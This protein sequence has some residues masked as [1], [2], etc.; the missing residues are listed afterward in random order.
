LL[1][2]R[3]RE[4][5]WLFV[6][7]SLRDIIPEDHILRRVDRVLNLGWLRDEVRELYNENEGR[8]GI[9]P[10]AAVRLML[11]GF[12]HGIV[13]DRKLLREAQV[14]IA[15]RWFAGY[16][17]HEELPDH[18]SLTRIRQRWGAERFKKIFE[19]TVGDCVAHGLVSG[20][21]VHID[22]TL[23]RANASMDSL[24]RIHA[25]A[26]LAANSQDTPDPNRGPQPSGSPDGSVPGS[27]ARKADTVRS[28]TDPDVT[29]AKG[30]FGQ[31]ARPRYKQHTAVDDRAQIIVDVAVTTGAVPEERE[32]LPQLA[33]IEQRL[34]VRPATVTTDTQYGIT[35]NY[36]AL[37]ELEIRAIIPPQT[38]CVNRGVPISM[39][40]FDARYDFF[41][42]PHGRKLRYKGRD[43]R[44]QRVYRS[45]RKDCATCPL[46]SRCCDNAQKVRTLK[47]NDGYPALL[48]ARRRHLRREV[49]DR[50]RLKR[51]RW[52]VE[53]VHGE[54]KEQHGLGRA[55][56]RG[57]QN[58]EI[59][60][61]LTA[62]VINLKRLA[63][64]K[65]ALCAFA[66]T[67]HSTARIDVLTCFAI[68]WR[69]AA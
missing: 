28:T 40:K 19:R 54:A 35:T 20:E 64:E 38:P 57:L 49:L 48:R 14:N 24:V 37:E 6:A 4:Q 46:R 5:E 9:D 41:Q 53:G 18:S 7:G 63:R 51:H 33:R 13:Q 67:R 26:V 50:M 8:P 29:L 21:T 22:A 66:P 11:A 15:I 36:A 3:N 32:L 69:S 23:I 62:A 47:V 39:F 52:Q 34:G 17:L 25:E 30:A 44:K 68:E 43:E 55:V 16:Q 45:S 60:A 56:R 12:F 65:P 27:K 10:E 2:R 31:P 58:M 59:Q 42:C 1:E 61:Y